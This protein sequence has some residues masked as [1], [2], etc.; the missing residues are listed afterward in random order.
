MVAH[1]DM[2]CQKWGPILT[3]LAFLEHTHV[4]SSLQQYKGSFQSAYHL[5]SPCISVVL[6]IKTRRRNQISATI[7]QHGATLLDHT[8]LNKCELHNSFW[9]CNTALPA[10]HLEYTK[11]KNCPNWQNKEQRPQKCSSWVILFVGILHRCKYT[12]H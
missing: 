5:L 2:T 1:L 11:I 9:N 7:F 8:Y 3:D 6:N 12:I 4:C 10:Y